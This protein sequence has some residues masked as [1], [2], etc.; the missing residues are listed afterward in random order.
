MAAA[1]AWVA[2]ALWQR[3]VELEA[4]K[5]GTSQTEHYWGYESHTGI[6]HKPKDIE[7]YELDEVEIGPA[8]ASKKEM[9]TTEL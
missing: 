8:A 3:H 6:D 9:K 5:A 2:W 7:D 1:L 4:R